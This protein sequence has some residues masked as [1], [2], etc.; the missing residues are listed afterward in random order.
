[1]PTLACGRE[2][3]AAQAGRSK[4]TVKEKSCRFCGQACLLCDCLSQ[5]LL[6]Y[7]SPQL[8]N[9]SPEPLS[10]HPPRSSSSS[11]RG[12]QG[13]LKAHSFSS[14]LSTSR[15]LHWGATGTMRLWLVSAGEQYAE[16]ENIAEK[17]GQAG[18]NVPAGCPQGG[19]CLHASCFW[20]QIRRAVS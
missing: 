6:G 1:M 15:C 10:F 18:S 7:P 16:R 2:A 8:Q 13:S 5:W 4:R 14:S 19:L 9:H 20:G 17:L 11:W 12:R 3:P